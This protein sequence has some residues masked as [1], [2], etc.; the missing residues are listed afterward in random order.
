MS[1]ARTLGGAALALGVAAPFAGSPYRSVRAQID[2]AELAGAVTRG[3]DHVSAIQLAGWIKDRK[4]GLRVIDVRSAH[5]FQ[6]FAIPTAEN[7]PIADIAKAR[8]GKD[9]VVVLYSE[10]GAHAAQAWVFL[11]A[12]GVRQVYFLRSGLVDWMD[13]VVN[14]VLSPD[15]SPQQKQAFEAAAELSRYFGGAPRVGEPGQ[16][17]VVAPDHEV[18]AL[19]ER[20]RR[21]GC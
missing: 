18:A 14:P 19:V 20:A 8:F 3:E 1:V 13:E 12:A 10:G 5:E 21:R 7:V 17:A 4:P 16:P 15:A 2:I 6:A 9:D 11:R